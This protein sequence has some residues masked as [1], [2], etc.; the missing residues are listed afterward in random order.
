MFILFFGIANALI[1]KSNQNCSQLK[2]GTKYLFYSFYTILFLLFLFL[3]N[4]G[5]L[6]A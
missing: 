1:Y 4:G 3:L 2:I 5:I 6:L